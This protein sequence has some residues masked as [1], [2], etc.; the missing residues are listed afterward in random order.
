MCYYCKPCLA[1][2]GCHNNTRE[3][4]GTMANKELRAARMKCHALVDPL[5]RSGKHGRGY[6]YARLAKWFG[7][8]THVGGS[9]LATCQ[10]I[11]ENFEKIFYDH[12]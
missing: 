4:L 10:Q 5:W 2:V 1:Y 9:N 7:E 12:K 3:P 8:D 6:V 11:T